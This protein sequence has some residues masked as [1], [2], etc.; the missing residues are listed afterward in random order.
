MSWDISIVRFAKVY[1]S[2]EEIPDDAEPQSLGSIVEIHNK[3]LKHFPGTDW[4]D[5]AWGMFES[6]FG[7]IE[8]NLGDDDPA[9]SMM[10]H[11]RASNEIV[12]PILA[13]C[14]DGAYQAIDCS[15]GALLDQADNPTKGL[16]A[17][18][19]YRDQIVED[20]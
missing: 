4:S 12:A 7:S 15:S 11:I 3:V 18:R 8:F 6:P 14:K 19:A 13:L 17:W 9:D 20:D 1:E 16:E 2:I 10:L 5:P